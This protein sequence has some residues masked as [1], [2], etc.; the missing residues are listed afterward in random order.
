MITP[1]PSAPA[2]SVTTLSSYTTNTFPS[3]SCILCRNTAP[4][5][6]L[7]LGFITRGRGVQI[8]G[9]DLGE[10]L[11]TTVEKTN[12]DNISHLPDALS[13]ALPKEIRRAELNDASPSVLAGIHDKYACLNTILRLTK[14]DSI[15]ALTSRIRDLFTDS[16]SSLTLSTIHRAKGLEWPTVFLLDRNLI[17]SPWATG[18]DALRQERNLL[19]VAVTR[20]A[21]DLV[22]ITSDCWEKPSA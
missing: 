16:A 13:A 11:I 17:P 7:A 1:S 21:V 2:G 5:V 12:C 4:L 14:P 8:K 6:A 15:S 9:R 10:S 3:G 18:P 20:A 22:Y 19:Y